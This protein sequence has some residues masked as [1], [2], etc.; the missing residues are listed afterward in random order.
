VVEMRDLIFDEQKTAD[1]FGDWGF[2]IAV[3]INDNFIALGIILICLIVIS[4][5]VKIGKSERKVF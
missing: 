5:L 1:M 3:F 2:E 4:I